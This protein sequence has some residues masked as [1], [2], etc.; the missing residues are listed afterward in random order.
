MPEAV[1]TK[2][3]ALGATNAGAAPSAPGETGAPPVNVTV[4]EERQVPDTGAGESA[5]TAPTLP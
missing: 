1:A 3:A 2:A 4:A 5:G